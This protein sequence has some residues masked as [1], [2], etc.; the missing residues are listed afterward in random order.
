MKRSLACPYCRGEIEV[1]WKRYWYSAGLH[2]SCPACRKLCRIVTRPGWIQY[3]SWLVQLLPL[4]GAYLSKNIYV[5]VAVLPL[6]LPIFI[7]DKKLDE[8]YGVLKAKN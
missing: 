8:R 7:L 5:T 6:Y 2:Y 3:T 4:A 1:T